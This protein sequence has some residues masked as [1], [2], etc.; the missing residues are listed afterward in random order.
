GPAGR[1]LAPYGGWHHRPRRRDDGK[2]VV[3]AERGAPQPRPG[4]RPRTAFPRRSGTPRP[5]RG[6][7]D[8]PRPAAEGRGPRR[9]DR[10][11]RWRRP[12]AA[13]P[14]R[15]GRRLETC[16]APYDRGAGKPPDAAR[17]EI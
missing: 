1:L 12:R 17:G 9:A 3:R 7:G 14:H 2:P 16:R 4:D 13:Q 6:E 10:D 5:A 11:G 8:R 15:A